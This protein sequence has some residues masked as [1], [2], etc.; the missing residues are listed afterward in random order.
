MDF[1]GLI[2]GIKAINVKPITQ[3]EITNVMRK[4][5]KEFEPELERLNVIGK[6]FDGSIQIGNAYKGSCID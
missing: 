6:V 2:N 4:V 1:E 5:E 3:E